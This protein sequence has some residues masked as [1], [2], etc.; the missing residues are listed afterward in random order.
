[1][2]NKN[3]FQESFINKLRYSYQKFGLQNED[4]VEF[5]YESDF[6]F[7][8]L[9]ITCNISIIEAGNKNMI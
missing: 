4:I 8:P 6:I 3:T 5:L 9:R 1:M 2:M 7:N